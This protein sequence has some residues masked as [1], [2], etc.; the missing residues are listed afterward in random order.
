M[1][2]RSKYMPRPLALRFIACQRGKVFRYMAKRRVRSPRDISPE[3]LW[4]DRERDVLDQDSALAV[5]QQIEGLAGR[6]VFVGGGV[7]GEAA[8]AQD[9]RGDLRAGAVE[10][11]Q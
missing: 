2:I 6:R 10:N 5:E 8:Q 1:T 7:F 11:L 4:E 3:P 9:Q